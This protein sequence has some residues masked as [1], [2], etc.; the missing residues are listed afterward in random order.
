MV[1]VVDSRPLLCVHCPSANRSRCSYLTAANCGKC[2]VSICC[3][4]G[5]GTTQKFLTMTLST[6]KLRLHVMLHN[7][8]SANMQYYGGTLRPHLK[9]RSQRGEHVDTTKRNWK[10]L[11]R[12]T[13]GEVGTGSDPGQLEGSTGNVTTALSHVISVS[14]HTTGYGLGNRG[15]EVRVPV[16]SRIFSSPRRPDRLWGPPSLLSNGY[17]GLFLRG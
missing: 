8:C 12:S 10:W 13:G 7:V 3:H 16:G 15:V 4:S 2:A 9:D 5:Q 17:R 1:Q 14:T 6:V 11:F